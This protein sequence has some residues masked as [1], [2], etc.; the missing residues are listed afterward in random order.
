MNDSSFGKSI[1]LQPRLV[2]HNQIPPEIETTQPFKNDSS[3]SFGDCSVRKAEV[4]LEI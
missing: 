2:G 3:T 1:K 4:L